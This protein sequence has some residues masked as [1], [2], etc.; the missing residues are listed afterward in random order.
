LVI[1]ATVIVS[2][3]G[4]LIFTAV[5]TSAVY[6]LT[7]GE[8]LAAGPAVRDQPVRVAGNVVTG[9]IRR[10]PTSMV[11]HFEAEDPSGRIPVTYRGVLPDIFGDGVEVV[12]EGRYQ[13]DGVFTAATLL[14]KC[15]SKF[16]T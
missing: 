7:V 5:Q 1:V 12:V 8:L 16:E 15:P 2:A 3:V 4:Y 11:V 14:A 10:E 13:G 9:S 6:Y